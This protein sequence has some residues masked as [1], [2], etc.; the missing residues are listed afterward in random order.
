M[1]R[2]MWSR[3]VC[4]ALM[5][6]LVIGS[7]PVWPTNAVAQ[8]A[9]GDK[10]VNLEIIVDASGSMAAP[11]D[12][13]VLRID[14][15]KRVLKEV[16][17]QIPQEPGVNVGFRVYGHRGDNTDVG[18]P[19]SC[20]SSDLLVPMQ[21]VDP[22]A[23][24]AQV[25]ALQPVGWTPLGYALQQAANDF[26]QPAS[27]NVVNAIIMVTDG[28][29]TCDADPAAIAGQLKASPAGI[30][31]HV[32]GFGTTPDELAIL[33]GITQASGGQLLGSNNAGQLMSALFAI[34]EE[35]QV[36]QETGTGETRE[37]PLGIGRV[38]R[39]GDYD[40]S[41]LSVTPNANDVVA[42]ENQFNEPPAEGNQ[43]F[44]ARVSVTYAGSATGTPFADLNFQ[45]VGDRS[46]SYT[47]FNNDCG[48]YPDQAYNIAELFPGGSAEFNVC[49][50]IASSDQG[51]LVM[52][53]E[54]LFSFDAS[55]VWFSLG[56]PIK[57]VV[58]PNA[59]PI[60]A[61][62]TAPTPTT[63]VA[64]PSSTGATV[65][66][67]NGRANPIPVGSAGRVG[68][69]DVSVLSVTPN[70]N[71]IVAVENQFNEPPGAGQQFFM[72]RVRVTYIGTATGNPSAELNFQAVGDKSASYTIFN[73]DCGVYPEQPYDVTEL[74]SGGAA[75]F[76]VCWE[77]AVEDAGSL[78]M[79][80]EP[81]FDFNATPVWFSLGNPVSAQAVPTVTAT[82]S[83]A[84]GAA[85]SGVAINV[86]LIDISYQPSELTIPAN[87]DVT[88]TLTNSGMLEHSFVMDSPR[89]DSGP[90]A[91]GASTT[92]TFNLP[93]GTYTFSCSVPGHK[94]A[95]MVGTIIAQ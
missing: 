54:P 61:E 68:D 75:E 86:S 8:E 53:V 18:R 92:V 50:E 46:A 44:L 26:T 6:A 77:I 55:P 47:T 19:E 69:Y 93:P 28:L 25:D 81:V 31:T 39:V 49:W 95:G 62:P 66:A 57:Q 91:P 9:G 73:N 17:A 43:F 94:E 79:Y 15:A 42:M 82:Q 58:D 24:T 14:A 80:V 4:T 10:T 30:T 85:P 41:V 59:T 40:V 37:S 5:V 22:A 72:A 11:T 48:V 3:I 29:E 89:M 67:D 70:A 21:G 71:D 52:Y 74:F 16:I 2:V 60:P 87:T 20:V 36:V 35:L 56:N 76:N 7:A 38:G 27:E 12:T 78:V 32:I 84:A 63:A 83:A 90:L 23:L 13:G 88:L 64:P 45:A 51:S 33:N 34:L 1:I 65:P